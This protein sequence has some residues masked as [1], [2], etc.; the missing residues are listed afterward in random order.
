MPEISIEKRSGFFETI[1]REMRL[2]NYSPKTIKT[3]VSCLRRFTRYLAP[4]HPREG[5]DADLRG[6]LLHL[7]DVEKYSAASISQMIN[8]LRFLYV[9]LYCRPLVVG[10]IPRPQKKRALPVVL[11]QEEVL[12][13]FRSVK[14]LKQRTILMLIYSAGLRVGEKW[15][16]FAAQKEVRT[17][18][19]SLPIL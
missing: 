9:E 5:T 8:A 13:L 16:I 19:P 18:I 4:R 14:N 3:Y 17:G 2:R 10:R 7:V 1:S 6:F 11:S 15:F 12:D